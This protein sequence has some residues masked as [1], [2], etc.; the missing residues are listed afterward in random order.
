M[1]ALKDIRIL[2]YDPAENCAVALWTES[3]SQET[4]ITCQRFFALQK[5]STTR[6]QQISQLVKNSSNAC[7]PLYSRLPRVLSVAF[8]YILG[9]MKER[10]LIAKYP[11]HCNNAEPLT[12]II[13]CGGESPTNAS[14]PSDLL[15][16]L[17]N[18]CKDKGAVGSDGTYDDLLNHFVC[19]ERGELF[20]FLL[21]QSE[22]Q[23]FVDNFS[24]SS[25]EVLQISRACRHSLS[26]MHI[27]GTK[28]NI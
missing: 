4:N 27:L 23:S 9:F 28:V 22:K 20:R 13:D 17:T 1:V 8:G 7:V 5:L 25:V 6:G 11:K 19:Q 21:T 12:M 24:R 26:W 14:F 3:S 16:E 2:P 18:L 10:H 15:K